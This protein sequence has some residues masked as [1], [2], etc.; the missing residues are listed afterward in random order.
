MIYEYKC[1]KCQHVFSIKKSM[2]APHPEKCPKCRRKGGIERYFTAEALPSVMYADRPPWT[3]KESKRFKTAK[4]KGKE[5]KIDPAKHGDVGAWNSPG[6][7]IQPKPVPKK[8][9]K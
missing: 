1:S 4:F 7:Y 9:K 6:E 8:R 2:S 5:Y 3:Y